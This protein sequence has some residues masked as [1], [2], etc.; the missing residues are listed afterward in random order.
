MG[1]R[2][3]AIAWLALAALLLVPVARA[4]PVCSTPASSP[5]ALEFSCAELFIA[6]STGERRF[7]VEVAR[8]PA[9]H[10][11]GLMYRTEIAADG[12]MLFIYESS[13]EVSM[14]M[15][16]TFIP[17]DIMFIAAD[18]RITHIAAKASPRSETTIASGGPV[19]AVLE[20]H[21]G[22][23]A[24]LGIRAGDRVR[25]DALALTP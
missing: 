21:A 7:E 11:H 4:K 20:V 3:S 25:T 10:A 24:L 2:G 22:T 14:W 8:T 12:G 13:G 16:N 1:G 17:L 19:R 15:K 5:R 6:T 23:V 9:Q 18:G